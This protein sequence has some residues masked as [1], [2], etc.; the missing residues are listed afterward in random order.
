MAVGQYLQFGNLAFIKPEVSA[1]QP[2]KEV[3]DLIQ[4][5]RPRQ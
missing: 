3:S 1:V 4:H 2:M 5:H